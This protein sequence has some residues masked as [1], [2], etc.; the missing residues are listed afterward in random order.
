MSSGVSPCVEPRPYAL[1]NQIQNYLWGSRGKQAYIPNVLLYD[2][3][4]KFYKTYSKT[5]V[6]GVKFKIKNNGNRLLQEVEV[7]VYFKN[8]KG[9]VIAEE[10][11]R[12]VLAM[13]KSFSGNQVILK[14]NY[15][16]QMDEGNFYKAEGIPT[17][18]QEGAVDALDRVPVQTPEVIHQLG[19]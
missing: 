9:T 7:T 8:A 5:K 14:E 11:Y 10:R 13:K 6:P 15:I 12:P 18:W 4:A 1:K 19:R 16:W 3:E 2:L 17:E